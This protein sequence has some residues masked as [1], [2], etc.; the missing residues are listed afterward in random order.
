M[1]ETLLDTERIGR[2]E[3]LAAW[4][5]L[6]SLDGVGVS[7]LW[8][9]AEGGDVEAEW[10]LR[11]NSAMRTAAHAAAQVHLDAGIVFTE[12]GDEAHP[13]LSYG[14]PHVPAV[15]LWRS[16]APLPPRASLPTVGIVGTRR[17]SRL[18]TEV[19]RELGAACAS[20]GIRVVSG[21]ANGI[22]AAAHRGALSADGA[23]PIGV[24]G[25]GLDVVYPPRNAELWN[26]VA[27]R[28]ALCSEYPL[29]TEPAPWRFP[30]RNRILVAQ[31]D[32]VVVVESSD[33]G[34]S[35][36]TA[37]LA[38]ERGVPVLAVP[39]SVRSQTAVGTNRLLAD[40]CQ[41]CLGPED[42]FMALGFERR[43]DPGN[44][45]GPGE[46]IE[47]FDASLSDADTAVLDALGW[48]PMSSEALANACPQL[49]LGTLLVAVQ[50]LVRRGVLADRDGWLERIR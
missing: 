8:Q 29:G 7:T 10:R 23:P 5:G 39:G 44:A 25:T 46:Q 32:V 34:G 37:G 19:A 22:D 42:I 14:D 6:A 48:E 38:G 4:L 24:V 21:L 40:G 36:I 50:G 41:P 2:L 26:E 11:S 3:R 28:G 35:L 31:S 45:G 49:S 47:L 33:R 12:H 15:L 1:V 17:A 27:H 9:I 18:G 30:A 13:S 20:A 43:P 16:G